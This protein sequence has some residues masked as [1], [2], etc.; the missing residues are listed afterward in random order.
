MNIHCL[1]IIFEILN[2]TKRIGFFSVTERSSQAGSFYIPNLRNEDIARGLK[3]FENEGRKFWTDLRTHALSL[4]S[5]VLEDS[6][7][8]IEY[9]VN[10]SDDSMI[11]NESSESE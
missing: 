7:R 3:A 4:F 8:T 2:L 9:P 1:K 5:N 6:D 11:E 10:D